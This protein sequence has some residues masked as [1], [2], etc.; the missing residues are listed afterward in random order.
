MTKRLDDAGFCSSLPLEFW[1]LQLPGGS[2]FG[3]GKQRFW[4]SRRNCRA[5]AHAQQSRLELGPQ[6]PCVLCCSPATPPLMIVAGLFPGHQHSTVNQPLKQHLTTSVAT[7]KVKIKKWDA[8]ATWR[9]DIPDDDVCGICQVHFDGTCPACK[10]PG[11][12]CSLRSSRLF[13]GEK[14]TMDLADDG[15]CSFGQVWTQ[16]SH[17]LSPAPVQLHH[18]L[19]CICQHCILE[20]IKQESAKGQCPMCR[21]SEIPKATHCWLFT[22]TLI[23]NSNGL[24]SSTTSR[25]RRWQNSL[26]YR[27]KLKEEY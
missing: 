10:Y 27:G 24:A 19:T 7:M 23:Q 26:R 4:P 3:G 17:G 16:L 21:Q 11:D 2:S 25:R 22:L 20:W 14:P 15:W 9:W 18:G 6:D 8:V 5:P 13:R 12:D 1:L